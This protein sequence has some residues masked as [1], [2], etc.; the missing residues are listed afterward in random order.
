MGHWAGAITQETITFTRPDQGKAASS[1]QGHRTRVEGR[2]GE[3][4][5]E[6]GLNSKPSF[7]YTKIN[8][9]GNN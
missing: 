8:H 2:C 5:E 7:N 9:R 4:M 6:S 1:L 3:A